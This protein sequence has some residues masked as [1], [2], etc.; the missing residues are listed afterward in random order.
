MLDINQQIG[1]APLFYNDFSLSERVSKSLSCSIKENPACWETDICMYKLPEHIKRKWWGI[2]SENYQ[3]NGI[4]HRNFQS[5]FD[6]VNDFAIFKGIPVLTEHKLDVLVRPPRQKYNQNKTFE[7]LELRSVVNLGD[8]QTHI[9]IENEEIPLNS[10]D[11]IWVPKKY[12]LKFSHTLNKLDL[13]VLL[14]ITS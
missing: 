8:E 14:F 1:V 3:A 4:K 7:R 2:V 5:F 11:G 12:T 9:I 10:R 6:A 13:D